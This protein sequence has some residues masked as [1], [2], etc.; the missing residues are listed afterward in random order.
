MAKEERRLEREEVNK[1]RKV[2]QKG[3][4][5]EATAPFPLTTAD[6]VELFCLLKGS[7]INYIRVER[8]IVGIQREPVDLQKEVKMGEN[9]EED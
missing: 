4:A 7:N 5:G 9:T 8:E 6:V 3:A 2:G 1:L